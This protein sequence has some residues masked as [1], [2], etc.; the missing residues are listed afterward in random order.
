MVGKGSKFTGFMGR[1]CLR[2]SVVG[3]GVDP[4]GGV[5]AFPMTSE[6][7]VEVVV[8]WIPIPNLPPTGSS[9]HVSPPIESSLLAGPSRAPTRSGLLAL[10]PPDPALRQRLEPKRKGEGRAREGGE[11]GASCGGIRMWESGGEAP[12]ASSVWGEK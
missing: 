3:K 2:A 9:L 4:L 12:S 5:V 11:G 10:P 1:S 8:A 7:E 6:V